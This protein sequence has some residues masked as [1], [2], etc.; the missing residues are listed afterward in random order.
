M[1][2]DGSGY[3]L[4]HSIGMFRGKARAISDALSSFV[5]DWSEPDDAQWAKALELRSA[6]IERWRTLIGAPLGT[7]TTTENVTAALF[8]IIGGLPQCHLNGRRL[9]V[10]GDCFPS[11]HFLLD[12]LARRFGFTLDTV[13]LRPGEYWVREE[14]I[15]RRWDSNVGLALLTS[16]TSTASYRCDLESLVEHGRRMGSLI[17]VDITQGAG[18]LPYRVDA[19]HV[20]FIVSSSLKWLCGTPGAG[21]LYVE[22]SLL[23]SCQPELRGWF[24]QEDI[25]S[26]QID[27]FSFAGDARRFD[28]GTPSILAC[29]GT[30]PC[31]AWHAEQE[32]AL[33]HNRMLVDKIIAFADSAGFELASPQDEARRGGSIM[34]RLPVGIDGARVVGGLRSAGVFADCRGATLRLSPG[35]I[36][37]SEGVERLFETLPRLTYMAA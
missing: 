33:A 17:G 16:V 20:D 14:D 15:L 35:Y 36:T 24:S 7:V 25:F 37:T 10:A 31:L 12:G 2:P 5:A 13:P 34:V 23:Q 9:L 18:I 4:Y 27:A 11:L 22:P 3:L 30:L 26:W 8:S 1:T 28:H 6:F 29:V 19:P 32:P 21:I